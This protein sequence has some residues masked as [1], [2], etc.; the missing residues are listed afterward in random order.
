MAR[1][2][3]RWR[4]GHA[5]SNAAFV[6]CLSTWPCSQCALRGQAALVEPDQTHHDKVRNLF[7]RETVTGTRVLASTRPPH[8]ASGPSPDVWADGSTLASSAPSRRDP[9]GAQARDRARAIHPRFPSGKREPL[10]PLALAPV[11]LCFAFSASN[12]VRRLASIRVCVPV[13][14]RIVA[15][16]ERRAPFSQLAPEVSFS[17][18][19][20]DGRAL[21]HN[22]IVDTATLTRS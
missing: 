10:P 12:P 16:A 1:C 18:F 11:F 21:H 2:A 5:A 3:Y 17:V 14:L 8:R 6:H 22:S 15:Q 20:Q 4:T 7:Q 13:L 9:S 19:P